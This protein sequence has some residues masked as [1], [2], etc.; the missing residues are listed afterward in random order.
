M[1]AS[2]DGMGPATGDIGDTKRV[3]EIYVQELMHGGVPYL[4]SAQPK[5]NSTFTSQCGLRVRLHRARCS[6][7][8][9]PYYLAEST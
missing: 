9:H 6:A 3:V 8:M 4:A 1:R 2:D 5:M 7:A